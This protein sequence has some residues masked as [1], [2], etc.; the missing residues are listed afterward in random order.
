MNACVFLQTEIETT[1]M[2]ES[3]FIQIYDL[4]NSIHSY[5]VSNF[6]T[7]LDFF[8]INKSERQMSHNYL[9]I[10]SKIK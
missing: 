4:L 1:H 7:F 6:Q 3:Y 2:T 9:V 5:L 8:N 10:K